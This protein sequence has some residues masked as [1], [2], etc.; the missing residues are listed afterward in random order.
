MRTA[1]IETA[2]AIY[3]A[4][5]VCSAAALCMA[6][7]TATPVQDV[8]QPLFSLLC[9]IRLP[10]FLVVDNADARV[11]EMLSFICLV[12]L[13]ILGPTQEPLYRTRTKIKVTNLQRCPPI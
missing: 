6:L 12:V 7:G 3:A 5:A 4:A 1:A 2:T 13:L 10:F 9:R 11:K 8:C